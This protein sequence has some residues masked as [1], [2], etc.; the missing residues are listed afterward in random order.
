MY[1]N[2][3]DSRGR[4]YIRF[5]RNIGVATIA[6]LAFITAPLRPIHTLPLKSCSLN[7]GMHGR[8]AFNFPTRY[9]LISTPSH[10]LCLADLTFKLQ[11]PR[12]YYVNYL[13]TQLQSIPRHQCFSYS[14]TYIDQSSL[15]F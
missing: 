12:L 3:T 4:L 7:Q 8:N 10:N 6:Y 9:T 14:L 11:H 15:S 1:L 13:L 2:V 5:S